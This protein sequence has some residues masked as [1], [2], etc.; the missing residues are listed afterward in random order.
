[1]RDSYNTYAHDPSFTCFSAYIL[2][3]D[4]PGR[5]GIA[6]VRQLPLAHD[7]NLG[8]RS[9]RKRRLHK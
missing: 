1:M 7:P 9:G 3:L 4:H 5:S 2:L 8:E 6:Y